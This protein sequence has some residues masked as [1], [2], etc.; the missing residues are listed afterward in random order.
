M[1][2]FQVGLHAAIVALA[3]CIVAPSAFAA[4]QA[5]DL[6]GRVV[7][8][9]DGDTLTLVDSSRQQHKIR[10]DG[11]DAPEKGQAFG[12]RSRRSLGELAHERQA[13]AHCSKSDR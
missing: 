9:A 8:I 6:S 12:Q 3:A 11:I 2:D 13:V 4:A 5:A 1:V 10:L 7:A